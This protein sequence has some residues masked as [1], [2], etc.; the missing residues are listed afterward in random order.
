L[1]IAVD[2]DDL[3]QMAQNAGWGE[4]PSELIRQMIETFRLG[5]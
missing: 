2:D 5:I 1:I 3:R 4:D